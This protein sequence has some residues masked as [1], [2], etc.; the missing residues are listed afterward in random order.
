M[1]VIEARAAGPRRVVTALGLAQIMAWGSSYYL[2]AVLARPIAADTGWPLAWVVAGLSGAL[3]TG[4]SVSTWVGRGIQRYGGRPVLAASSLLLAAGLAG[5]GLA[6]SLPAYLAAWLVVGVGM[7]AGLYDAAFATLGRL[8]GRSARSTIVTLTL[9]GGFASTACW[10]LSAFLLDHVGW[11]NTCFIYAA[12]Q[13]LFSF[14]LH[15]IA[16]PAPAPLPVADSHRERT[17]P[18][19]TGARQRAAL[20]LLGS[21][22]TLVATGSTVISVHLLALLQS[23]GMELAVAVGLGA[24]VGP[25]QVGARVIEMLFGRHYHP[26]WTMLASVILVGCGLTF[27]LVGASVTALG[28]ILYGAGIGIHSIARGALPL[29][30]FDTTQYARIMG[31]LALPALIGEALAPTAG[32]FLL[33]TGGASLLLGVLIAVAATNLTCALALWRLCRREYR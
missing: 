17:A 1:S 15:M 25:S 10:P 4:G 16:I 31:M 27:L 23:R 24:M 32:A 29:A 30:L 11:R 8:Y 20:V 13:L 26:I 33:E 2:L 5:I 28:L 14:P 21:I 9:F 19:L 3:V 6:T 18:H 7:G 22:V 12:V